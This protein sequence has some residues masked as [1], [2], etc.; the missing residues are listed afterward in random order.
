MNN[1]KLGQIGIGVVVTAFIL[2]L[3]FVFARFRHGI[4][5]ARTR[6]KKVESQ[7][8][9]TDC[10]EIEYATHG[11]GSPVLVVHGIFGGHDQGLVQAQGQVGEDFLAI[12]PSRF[13]YLGSSIPQ[14]PSPEKQADVF[15]CFLD[16]M[17][18]EKAAVLGTSAGG[19]SAIQFAL[20][21]PDHCAGLILVSSNA[22]GKVEFGLPPKPLSK[23]LFRLDFAF[24][25]M[26]STFP[27]RMY[28]IM[29]V[30][31]NYQMTPQE[32]REVSEVMETLLPVKPRAEGAIFDMYVSNPAINEGVPLGEISVPTLVIHALDDPLAD[33][34][35][36][37]AMAN[38]IPGA[39]LMTITKGGHPLLGHKDEIRE[40]IT[41]FI[42]SAE[43]GQE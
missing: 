40:R 22:P 32:K 33:Y 36:A 6:L 5:A 9:K 30:P 38:A 31:G 20:R 8:V 24:W 13:G 2:L 10:G 25:L 4:Q 26:T 12:I 19:T 15:A 14:N 34:D 27:S 37:Q 39:E 43:F 17:G 42:K 1:L 3:I 11:E 21:Y 7:V 16:A 28:G 18:I 41:Y 35:N 29:G 23:V